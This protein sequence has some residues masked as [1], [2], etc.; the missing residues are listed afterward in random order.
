[1]KKS[2]LNFFIGAICSVLLIS[3]MGKETL[4]K[5]Q[6]PNLKRFWTYQ[7]PAINF[8][9]TARQVS[10]WAIQQIQPN[11]KVIVIGGSSVLL[12]NGQQVNQTV[13]SNLQKL[14]GSD[15]VVLNLAVRGGASFGQGFYV[16]AYLKS[17]G[18][19]V[20]YVSEMNPGYVPPI[21]NNPPYSYF[22]WQSYYAD[23]I[24]RENLS[25]SQSTIRGLTKE[26]IMAFLNNRLYFMEL[27]NYISYNYINL[28]HSLT[29]GEIW[30]QPL[31]KYPDQEIIIPYEERIL[32]KELAQAF[33]DRVTAVSRIILRSDQ[34]DA[35]ANSYR[36]YLAMNDLSNSVMI[37]CKDEPT[38][39]NNLKPSE[40]EN[41]FN[42][43]INQMN[44]LGRVGVKTAFPCRNL[45]SKDYADV[46]HL[47]PE[48]ARKVA[49]DLFQV[50]R[51][52]EG[53]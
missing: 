9:P 26:R 37:F 6:F 38:Y 8:F 27:A 46:A 11:Q 22:F 15:Y 30:I 4:N 10:A 41:Y 19:D 44:A 5:P 23:I 40:R 24:A 39:I 18:Y 42:N 43:I 33:Q 51:H 52:K 34:L 17:L 12:G 21:Q 28:N 3:I 45:S 1:M 2:N 48:G 13:S 29:A 36:K 49:F 14:L 50:L 25:I 35:T 16:A 53:K 20:T 7:S 32:S 47:S 31:K